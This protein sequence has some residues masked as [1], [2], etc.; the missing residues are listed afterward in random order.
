MQVFQSDS[1]RSRM[2]E[3]TAGLPTKSAKIRKLSAAGFT[4]TQIADYLGI[5]Y[6]HVRNVLVEDERRSQSRVT[7]AAGAAA[8]SDKPNPMAAKV[9]IGTHGEVVL[10]PHVLQA[11]GVA[12]GQRLLVR[13]EDDEIKL[14][15]P[16]ATA[17]KVQAAI[18]EFVPRGVSLVDEL[19]EE[20]RREAA[21]ENSGE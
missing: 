3:L 7:I 13:F 20:R 21:R 14:M 18:R 17:R 2:D 11:A 8:A 9:E 5:I 6:Q 10:P 1:V 12:A 19:I 16:Q 15:T 4:R